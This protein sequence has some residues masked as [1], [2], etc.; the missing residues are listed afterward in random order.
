MEDNK[1]LIVIAIG[2][3]ILAIASRGE[4]FRSNQGFTSSVRGTS[5][6]NST[7]AESRAQASREINSIS[8][9]ISDL[10][11]DV[12]E[13]IENQNASVYRD[14]VTI[15]SVRNPGEFFEYITIRTNVSDGEQVN[16]T[17]WKLR[18]AVTG[19]EFPIGTGANVARVGVR[20]TEPIVLSRGD[21]A[22]LITD[23]SPINTSF[24]LNKCSGYL[25]QEINFIPNIYS[26]CP[27]IEE[28]APPISN[29]F[30]NFCLDYIQSISRCEIPRD[31]DF[32]D[33][34]TSE[35]EDFI[36][37]NANYNSCVAQ[38]IN[39]FDFLGSEWRVYYGRART[40]WVEDRDR[41]LLLDNL[42][43]VV[44]SYEI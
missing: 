27:S 17:G 34:L 10:S 15:S 29:N 36:L 32:P 19:N 39:D 18:S 12:Q 2:I 25:Q 22:V 31:R 6:E 14:R 11:S 44:D 41:I 40:L 7:S 26:R 1:F 24:R 21:E 30:N 43:R 28:I 9:Q 37:E 16:I 33:E 20:G 38:N 13:Y 42:G 8:R 5:S 3:I 23:R 35:C 4:I